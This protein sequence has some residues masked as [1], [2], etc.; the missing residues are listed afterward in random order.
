MC[1]ARSLSSC[2]GYE[3]RAIADE[4]IDKGAREFRNGSF[5]KD[6]LRGENRPMIGTVQERA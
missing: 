3:L 4:V 1:K 2:D 5:A 6:S